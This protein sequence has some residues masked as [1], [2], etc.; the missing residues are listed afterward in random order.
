MITNDNEILTFRSIIKVIEQNKYGNEMLLFF[1]SQMF[2][3][4]GEKLENVLRPFGEIALYFNYDKITGIISRSYPIFDDETKEIS[5]NFYLNLFKNY[6]Q[7]IS[8]LKSRQECMSKK[9]TKLVEEKF[10]TLSEEQGIV[11]I[12]LESSLA[13]SSYILFGKPWKNL[14]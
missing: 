14:K 7:G 8:L 3:V 13:I 11:N 12:D 6:S 10:K 9:M 5:S 4:Q 2:N 1:N